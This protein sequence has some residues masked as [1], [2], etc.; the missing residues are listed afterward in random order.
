MEDVLSRL[1]VTSDP[2]INSLRKLPA[3]KLRSLL[4][5]ALDLL[6]APNI[7]EPESSDSG[8]NDDASDCSEFV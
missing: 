6:I 3:R 1:L 4:P 8:S 5:K 2:Y 7:E